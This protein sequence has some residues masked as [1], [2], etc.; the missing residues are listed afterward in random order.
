MTFSEWRT[1]GY[2]AVDYR[3]GTGFSR[4]AWLDT[5]VGPD[6]VKAGDGPIGYD[7]WLD[8]GRP[9]PKVLQ[10]FPFD[11]YCSTPGSAE[12]RYVGMAAPEGLALTFRQ[13]VAAGSRTPTAC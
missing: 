5:I 4:L 7:T 8:A 10:A 3:P 13:W 12:I 2:P 1:L 11:K 9:T 6:P